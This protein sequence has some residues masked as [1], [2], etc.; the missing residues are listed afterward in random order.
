MEPIGFM[1]YPEKGSACELS[2][3]GHEQYPFNSPWCL[4][5]TLNRVLFSFQILVW[6]CDT[7]IGFNRYVME[8]KQFLIY[9]KRVLHMHCVILGISNTPPI[10]WTKIIQSIVFINHLHQSIAF[11]LGFVWV[12]QYPSKSPWC[13]QKTPNRVLLTFQVLVWLCNTPLG[14]IRYVMELKE[15]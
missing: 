6:L 5:I 2:S 3:Y 12:M 13:L 14:F 15:F 10:A 8:P 7:P 4:Q 9:L 11:L 1:G